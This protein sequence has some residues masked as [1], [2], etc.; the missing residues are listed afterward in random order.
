MPARWSSEDCLS[1][2]FC[3]T[4]ACD[5][6]IILAHMTH[7]F[8]AHTGVN[9]HHD[10][11]SRHNFTLQFVSET[12]VDVLLLPCGVTP[13]VTVEPFELIACTIRV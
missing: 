9:P 6:I 3:F 13:H 11:L 10:V 1:V 5:F 12:L 4:T 2:S 8:L 7:F